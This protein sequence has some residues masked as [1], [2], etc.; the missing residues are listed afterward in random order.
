MSLKKL[1]LSS[2]EKAGVKGGRKNIDLALPSATLQGSGTWGGQIEQSHNRRSL[3]DNDTLHAEGP[4][5]GSA[6][7]ASLMESVCTVRVFE[8]FEATDET[9]PPNKSCELREV[10]VHKG[11]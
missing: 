5:E 8:D 1:Q 11:S 4:D 9:L 2:K 6:D 10:C 3:G 7:Q